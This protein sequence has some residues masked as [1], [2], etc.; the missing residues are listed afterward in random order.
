MLQPGIGVYLLPSNPK[1][2]YSDI[3]YLLNR[4]QAVISWNHKLFSSRDDPWKQKEPAFLRQALFYG[5]VFVISTPL[6][7]IIENDPFVPCF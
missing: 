6:N 5:Q 1:K 2:S 3:I 7:R 4:I